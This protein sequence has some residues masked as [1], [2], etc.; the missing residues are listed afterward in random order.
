MRKEAGFE[1]QDRIQLYYSNNDR[2]GRIIESNR[3]E[4][5]EEVLAREIAE[6][7]ADGYTK[8]WNINDE[9]V[10]LTVVRI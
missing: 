6:G 3:E 10:V 4:I 2:I 7:K 9:R 5:A 1:V 8:E